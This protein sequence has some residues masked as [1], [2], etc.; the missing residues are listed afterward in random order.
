MVKSLFFLFCTAFSVA[1][2]YSCEEVGPLV[3]L[4]GGGGADTSDVSV[5][6]NQ[7][8]MVL[9]EDFTATNCPNCPDARE[10]IENLQEQYPGRIEVISVHQGILSV[11]LEPGDPVLK[12]Q[13]GENLANL[14]G[15]PLYWPVGAV[16]RIAWETSPGNFQELVDR[17][18]WPTFVAQ[19]LDSPMALQLGLNFQYDQ[20]ARKLSGS[21]DVA[22]LRTITEPLGITVLITENGIVATQLDG[23]TEIEDYVHHDVLRD[24]I[25]SV[26]G[27]PVTGS[28]T[29]GS[30]WTYNIADYI[31]PAEWLAD[32]C[33][34]VALISKTAG[35]RE[36]YQ[37]LAEPLIDP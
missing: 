31:V 8:R 10:I 21:V 35:G 28:K 29:E 13:D 36:V 14:L 19:Q 24:I 5:D 34:V 23:L 17:S 30:N 11:A 18:L 4:G 25:T 16:N 9:I 32:S 7:Q 1:S 20:A 27:D 22:F 3:N 6:T 26:P 37:V 12:T 33:R 15:P 2:F